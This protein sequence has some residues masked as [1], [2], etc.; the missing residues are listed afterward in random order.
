MYYFAIQYYGECYAAPEGTQYDRH[1]VANNC[2][3]GVGG[4][5]SNYVYSFKNVSGKT[6]GYLQ[7]RVD[8]FYLD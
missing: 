6:I 2:W 1:G 4:S 3:S 7:H 8:I 5:Y